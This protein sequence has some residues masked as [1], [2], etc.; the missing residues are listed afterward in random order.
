MNGFTP[1][2]FPELFGSL[3]LGTRRSPGSLTLTGHDRN[4]NWDVQSAKGQDGETSQLNGRKLGEFEASFYLASDQ[5]DDRGSNDFVEWESFQK[6]IESTV[7]GPTPVALPIYHPDL[8]RNGFTEVVCAGISGLI[9]DDRGGATVKVKFREHRPPKPKKPAKAKSKAS[10]TA[11]PGDPP[12]KP[13]PNAEAK[14][15]LAGLVDEAKRP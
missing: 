6:V 12:A 14:R 10:G 11:K 5:D 3:V 4:Q 8:S 15:E 9:W 7:A 2:N 13:D 1:H